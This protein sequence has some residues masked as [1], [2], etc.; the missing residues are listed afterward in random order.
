M[1]VQKRGGWR[2]F[3][4][5]RRYEKHARAQAEAAKIP[6]RIREFA[7]QV[8]ANLPGLLLGTTAPTP[9]P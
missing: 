7:R 1:E 5:V 8:E 6:V 3:H 4:S 2:S 9:L